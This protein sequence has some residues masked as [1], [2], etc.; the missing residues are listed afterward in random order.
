MRR[1]PR[2]ASLAPASGVVALLIADIVLVTLAVR[3]TAPLA[4][5]ALPETTATSTPNRVPSTSAPPTGSASPTSSGGPSAKPVEPLPLRNSIVALSGAVAWRTSSGSCD[6]GGGS[7]SVTSDGG[8]TWS[9]SAVPAQVVIRVRPKSAKGATVIATE[10]DCRPGVRLTADG[11]STWSPPTNADGTWFRDAKD[12]LVVHSPALRSERP[13]G[14]AAVLDLAPL[15]V[16]TA[17]VLCGDGSVRASDDRGASWRAV[18]VVP[19]A[20]ALDSRVEKAADTAYVVRVGDGCAGLQVV[21]VEPT[22]ASAQPLGCVDVSGG[23]VEPG[24]ITLSVNGPHG[25]LGVG[26]RVWRST[27][28]LRTWASG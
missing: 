13:C 17:H 15:T 3:Y 23:P 14:H 22:P 24:T 5:G 6:G 12:P 25:W 26:E 16:S 10:R 18:G 20:L 11:G 4:P 19:Q 9:R 7:V 28:D 2:S 27:D 1:R 21:R 8:R